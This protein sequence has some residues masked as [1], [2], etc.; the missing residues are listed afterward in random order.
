LYAKREVIDQVI[1][2]FPEAALQ[3]PKT[4]EDILNIARGQGGAG[5]TPLQAPL[6][7]EA[8]G[9]RPLSKKAPLTEL[10]RAVMRDLG[11]TEKDY[12]GLLDGIEM[13]DAGAVLE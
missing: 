3:N 7:T 12:R 11:K 4:M 8:P 9:S 1:A 6:Y 10:D 13:T 5:D 2:R